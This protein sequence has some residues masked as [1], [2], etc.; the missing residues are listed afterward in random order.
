MQ[1]FIDEATQQVYS[2]DDD[3]QAIEASGV[4]SFKAANGAP[5]NTPTSLQPYVVPAPTSAE[6][7]AQQA[8]QLTSQCEAAAQ[9]SLDSLARSW[10]YDNIVSAASYANSTV[11]QYKAEAAALVAWRDAT[12]QAAE[13][14]EAQIAAGTAQA[15]ATVASF[16][17]LLPAAPS[18]PATG[19]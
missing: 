15:P 2:F 8:A 7:A 12:W 19:A 14:L 11:A 4:Y 16:V 5:L 1:T 3:I 18:R 10:G 6:I 17:A 13:S 9:S